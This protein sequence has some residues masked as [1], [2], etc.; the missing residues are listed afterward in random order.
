MIS[1]KPPLIKALTI[2][3]AVTLAISFSVMAT[4]KQSQTVKNNVKSQGPVQGKLH[5]PPKSLFEMRLYRDLGLLTPGSESFSS[6][7]LNQV[8]VNYQNVKEG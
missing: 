7:Y 4:V 5:L 1:L 8:L 3:V 6:N 2:A